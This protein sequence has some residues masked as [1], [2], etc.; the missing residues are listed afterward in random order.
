[1]VAIPV[2]PQGSAVALITPIAYADTDGTG[3]YIMRDAT[4]DKIIVV[5][6]QAELEAFIAI[7]TST[8]VTIPEGDPEPETYTVTY[9]GNTNTSG[10]APSA[11]TKTEDVTLVLRTNTGTLA[12][13]G[14][15]FD[16]WNTAANG[17]GTSYAVGANYTAN[18]A[19]TMYAKW[20]EIIVDACGTPGDPTDPD[21]WSPE[22]SGKAYGPTGTNT[23]A[24]ES[25]V[26]SDGKTNTAALYA[27]GSDYEAA[28]YCYTLTEDEVPAGTWYL[29]SYAELWAGYNAPAMSGGF[30]GLPS[31]GYWSSTEFSGFPGGLAWSL[32]ASN[33]G[34]NYNHKGI[35]Y[36]VRCLR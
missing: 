4:S 12:K 17:S 5:A 14:Y 6:D 21:C 19:A 28:Y 16:G 7:G 2:D 23:A 30:P 18:A 15:T 24:S 33:D 34:M 36:A 20:T 8:P 3:Y 31:G 25:T 27:L 10:T 22:V 35:Q 1:M 9:D 26:L 32:N 13:T 11:Q 29:P